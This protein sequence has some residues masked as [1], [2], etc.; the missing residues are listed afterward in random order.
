MKLRGKLLLVGGILGLMVLAAC[1]AGEPPVP[2]TRTV[3]VYTGERIQVDGE[4]MRDVQGWLQ[5]HLDHI[6]RDPGFLIRV[7]RQSEAAYPWTTTELVGDTAI[8]AYQRAAVDS[9]PPFVI[10]AHLRL[11]AERNQVA[12]WL[13]AA[14]EDPTLAGL[15]LE[16]A[17]LERVSDVW[18]LGRSVFDTQAHGPLDELLYANERGLLREFILATQPDRF[19]D[20]RERFSQEHPDWEETLQEFFQRTFDRDGPG[21]LPDRDADTEEGPDD[22]PPPAGLH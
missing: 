4:R 10:Y 17:I 16:E 9:E 1:G 2:Q 13:P 11:E 21:Y 5:P 18:L 19:E 12:D 3:I 14:E 20:E 7:N 8:T 22:D 6:E 15:D